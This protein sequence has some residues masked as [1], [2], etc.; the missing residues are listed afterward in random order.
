MKGIKLQAKASGKA[1]L[2]IYEDIG[3]GFWT[4]GITAQD[5]MKDL[6]A[7]GDVKTIDVRINSNGGSVFDGIAIYNALRRHSATKNVFV[8]GIAASIASVI[9]MSGDTITM[10]E[11]TFIMVHRASGLA[12]GNA[13]DMRELADVLEG[14]DTQLADIYAQRTGLALQ[15]V[16]DMMEAETW[17]NAQEAIGKGFADTQ[18]ETLKLAAHA[19]RSRFR[20]IPQALLNQDRRRPTPRL[21]AMRARLA[22]A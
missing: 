5:F 3:E 16:A 17:M 21:D 22:A 10:G 9:A 4:S 19:N 12:V 2:L 13:S 15:T 20:N 11:G 7:L 6:K 1:E 8:D 18:G 14:I